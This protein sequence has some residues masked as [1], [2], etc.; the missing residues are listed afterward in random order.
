M[1]RAS[2][3]STFS[4]NIVLPFALGDGLTI[5]PFCVCFDLTIVSIGF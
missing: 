3:C 5:C 2:R 1:M 4:N